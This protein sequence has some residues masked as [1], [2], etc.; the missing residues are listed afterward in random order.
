VKIRD[1]V[2]HVSR[3]VAVEAKPMIGVIGVAPETGGIATGTPW[4]HGGNMDTKEVAVGSTVYLPV[5]HDGGLLAIGDVHAVQADG[6]ICVSAVDVSSE[7]TVKVGIKEKMAPPWPVVET[8]G[9]T[10]LV[11]SGKTLD[12]AVHEAAKWAVKALEKGLK[13]SWEDAYML[14]SLVVDLGISQ[15]VDPK[16]TVKAVIP[17]KI[18]STDRVLR[19]LSF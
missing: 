1:D 3:D 6:E 16:R 19:A 13:L 4:K 2:I 18:M 5:F 11:V 17:K 15:V 7:I 10:V 9:S 8:H 12:E 14:S